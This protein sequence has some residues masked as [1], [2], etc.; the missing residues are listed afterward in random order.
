MLCCLCDFL[1]AY[2]HRVFMLFFSMLNNEFDGKDACFQ[3]FFGKCALAFVVF[4]KLE[5]MYPVALSYIFFTR[6]PL[7]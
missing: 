7:R 3:W 5:K 4:E 1:D 6:L 2:W